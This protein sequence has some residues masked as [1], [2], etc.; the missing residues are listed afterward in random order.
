VRGDGGLQVG[1]RRVDRQLELGNLHS[2]MVAVVYT[3]APG[4]REREKTGD[5]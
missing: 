3:L 5:S 2:C 4:Q 1:Q